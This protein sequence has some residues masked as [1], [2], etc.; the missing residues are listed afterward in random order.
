MDDAIAV[1]LEFAA[2]STRF[3]AIV[4]AEFAPT[5]CVGISSV[6]SACHGSVK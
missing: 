6:R 4:R 1:A 3:S 2:R 5:M